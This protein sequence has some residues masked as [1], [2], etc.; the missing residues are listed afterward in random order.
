MEKQ[1][2]SALRLLLPTPQSHLHSGIP[3]LAAA[4][5]NP[6]DHPY[7]DLDLSMSIGSHRP[8]SKGKSETSARNLQVLKQ[9]TA[10]QIRVAAV[11]KAYAERVRE[12]TRREL[13]LAEKEFAQAR[14]LWK[15]AREEVEKVERMKEM[16]TRRISSNSLEITCHTCMKRCY[17]LE[18]IF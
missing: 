8:P 11:E 13:E 4:A 17:S 12:M 1:G 14:L 2:E 16:A 18:F 5:T 15:K 10:E 6:S 7:L 9:Q 3:E